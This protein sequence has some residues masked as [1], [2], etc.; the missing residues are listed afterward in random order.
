MKASIRG[1]TRR[2]F[3]AAVVT[4]GLANLAA[5]G[6]GNGGSSLLPGGQQMTGGQPTQLKQLSSDA[7]TNAE[8]QH[9]TEVEPSLAAFGNNLVAALQVGR[10]FSGGASDIGF[11]VS[12]DAGATWTNGL[13]PGITKFQGGTYNAASDPSIAYDQAHAVWLISSLALGNGTDTVVVSR[14]TDMYNWSVPIVASFTADADK[15]WITCDNHAGSRFYGHCYVEWDDP[16]RPANGLVWMSTSADGGVTWSQALNTADM[17]AGVG[18][19]PVVGA[20]GLVVVP[21]QN[22]DGTQMRAFTSADGGDG[23]ASSVMISSITDHLVA[24]NMRTAALPSAAADADGRVYVVWQD[25][26]FRTNC[27]SND[28]VL[29]TSSDG[30][31]WTAPAGIPI[32]TLTTPAVD[33]FIPGLAVNPA[34]GSSSAALALTY[35]FYPNAACT[36]ANCQLQTGYIASADGGNTWGAA[37]T[38]AG[39]MTLSWLPST[40]SGVMVGD[41][42]ATAYSNSQP[43][44]VFAVAQAKA[45]SVFNQAIY[46]TANALPQMHEAQRRAMLAH[47]AVTQH[48]DHPPRRFYDLDHEHPIPRR[49]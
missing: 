4:A 3:F 40:T 47:T 34:T 30:V 20:N 29:S 22:A 1:V 17:L 46:T 33:H 32:E 5:C 9:A 49:K 16:S 28:I 38:L 42:V 25:C 7:F 18:G 26:R 8:S 15:N 37:T 2:W 35:Y 21:I 36:T 39:P 24:G 44:A 12:N 19:Q 48:A 31:N 41:Y 23:W 10:I 43:H 11:A 6:S 45:G 14:S 13:L 27:A